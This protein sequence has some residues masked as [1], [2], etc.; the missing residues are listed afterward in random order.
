MPIYRAMP[1]YQT[2]S[3]V[4]EDTQH[5][6]NLFALQRFG[7]IY[8]RIMNPTTAAFEERVA[9]LEGGVGALATGSGQAAHF[10]TIVSLMNAGDQLVASKTLYGGTITQFDVTLRRLGIDTVF[11]DPDDP[12]A[13]ARAITPRT[14][15]VYAETV[16]NPKI[17]V[18]D[19]EA[20]ANVAHAHGVPLVIDNTFATPYLCRP[21][22]WGADIVVH[23]A[24]KFI[25]GHGTSI[26]GVIV[27]SGRFKWDNGKFPGLT[28]PT[29]RPD[30]ADAQLQR[31]PL[32][33]DLR[34][35]RLD[36][37]GAG[38]GAARHRRGA[39]PVQRLPVPARAR[40]ARRAHAPACGEHE[41]GGGVPGRARGRGVGELPDAAR[42]PVPGV[43][44]QVS[45]AGPWRG[46]DVRHPRWAGGG[47][48]LH[49]ARAALQPPGSSSATWPI[50]VTPSRW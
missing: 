4:F 33:R 11:V 38:R 21:I 6:A 3:Y 46:A 36:H 25:G 34:R 47:A 40:D 16:A 32:L 49:R 18:V 24:T 7:H 39:E 20:L 48:A 43:G 1:I 8:T 5:A 23:S 44:A 17:N 28:E 26:G 10:L 50:S 41:G 13:F 30:R 2:T 45:A 37:E 35:L 15:A 27:D 12:E 42:Q 31:H 14:R 9:S 19:L 22:E 29:P